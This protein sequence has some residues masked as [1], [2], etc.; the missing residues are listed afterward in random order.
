MLAAAAYC[1]A[2]PRAKAAA[3]EGLTRERKALCS[4]PI[5]NGVDAV[6]NDVT[7][8]GEA[9]TAA[10]AAAAIAAAADIAVDGVVGEF[11]GGFW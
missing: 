7:L 3:D 4:P 2:K 11:D 9:A 5:N 6:T 1:R 10:A 8:V